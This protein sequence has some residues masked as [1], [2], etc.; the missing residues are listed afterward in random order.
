MDQ[1]VWHEG[2]AHARIAAPVALIVAL[3]CAA[4]LDWFSRHQRDAIVEHMSHR[5]AEAII[6][7]AIEAFLVT[8]LV[9]GAT[10]G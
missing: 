4:L 6:G 3:A 9:A 2:W 10:H 5:V 8:L 1:S 7:G